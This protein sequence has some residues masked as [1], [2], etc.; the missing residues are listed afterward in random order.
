MDA[1]AYVSMD[2][3]RFAH[4]DE[5]GRR[6]AVAWQRTFDTALRRGHDAVAAA[7]LADRGVAAEQVRGPS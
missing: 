7:R 3:P 1:V 6:A 5:R 4:L 2:D